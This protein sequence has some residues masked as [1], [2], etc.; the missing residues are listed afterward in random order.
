M[1]GQEVTV[2][3][4]TVGSLSLGTLTR[5]E[6]TVG[7]LDTRGFPEELSELGGFP[8]ARV[9]RRSAVHG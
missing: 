3:L 2:P 6:Q 7:I 1:S 5:A 4:A 8:L 9:L